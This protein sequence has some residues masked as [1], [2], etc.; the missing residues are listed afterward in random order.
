M[1]FCRTRL[2]VIP[3]KGDNLPLDN[4]EET[5]EDPCYPSVSSEARWLLHGSSYV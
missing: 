5:S 4:P 3:L 1:L 2:I